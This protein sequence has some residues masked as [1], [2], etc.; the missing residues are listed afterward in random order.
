MNIPH[1]V[2]E[3]RSSE[4]RLSESLTEQMIGAS[5][6]VHRELDPGLLESVYEERMCE[7]LRPRGIPFRCQIEDPVTY[8]SIQT[9]GKYRIDLIPAER[10]L[11]VYEAQLVTYLKLAGRRVGLLIN[12]NVAVLHRGILRRAL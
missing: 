10:F 5:I 9:G 6:E 2:T 4:G 7:E 12:F 8:K 1:P 11:G 3:A